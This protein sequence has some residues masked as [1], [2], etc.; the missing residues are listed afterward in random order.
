MELFCV[1]VI[2]GAIITLIMVGGYY[3]IFDKDP[4]DGNNGSDCNDS[5]G[6]RNNRSMDGHNKRVEETVKHAKKMGVKLYD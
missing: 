6:Y 5:F 2:A 1:G 3:V 4:S